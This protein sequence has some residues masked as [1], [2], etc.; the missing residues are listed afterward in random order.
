MPFFRRQLLGT[1]AAALVLSARTAGA[2]R[3]DTGIIRLGVLT[4]MSGP[5]RD[6][7]G[8]TGVICARQAVFEFVAANPQIK[9][10]LVVADHQNKADNAVSIVR[11]W[12]DRDG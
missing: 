12:F 5:Y 9:V 1:G 7:T 4:D 8:P 11:A 10:E 6:V 3:L 2:Q